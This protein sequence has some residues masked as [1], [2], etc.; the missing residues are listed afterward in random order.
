MFK[1]LKE[2][3]KSFEATYSEMFKA[4]TMSVQ[5]ICSELSI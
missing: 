1:E 4:P 2:K 5:S 3:P